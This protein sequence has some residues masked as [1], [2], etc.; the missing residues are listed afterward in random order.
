MDPSL[1]V[2]G[3]LGKI[4]CDERLRNHEFGFR[5]SCFTW[6]CKSFMHTSATKH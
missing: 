1:S 2:T 5:L 6:Q 4:W 3:I